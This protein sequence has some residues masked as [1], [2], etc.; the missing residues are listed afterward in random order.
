MMNGPSLFYYFKKVF[1]LPMIS[2]FICS[3][4]FSCTKNLIKYIK[5]RY[6]PRIIGN[7]NKI[8][9]LRYLLDTNEN[10]I[11]FHQSC[12]DNNLAPRYIVQRM[13]KI[14]CRNTINVLRVYLKDEISFFLDSIES[15]KSHLYQKWKTCW[16]SLS[17]F[18]NLLRFSKY[19][20][21][22]S[23]HLK[24]KLLNSN[25]QFLNI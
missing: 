1:P 18:L 24:S 22:N 6:S 9:H 16:S 10:N 20:T 3:Y 8:I 14:K 2:I 12:L 4:T 15:V 13:R 11:L 5:D 17:F 25:Q 19:L 7:L 21:N 23:F